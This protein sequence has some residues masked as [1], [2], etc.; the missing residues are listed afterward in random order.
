VSV[1]GNQDLLPFKFVLNQNYPNPFNPTTEIFF[2]IPKKQ[3]TEL[4]VYDI[5]GARVKTI[6]SRNLPA[7][8]YTVSWDGKDGMGQNVASGMYFYRLQSDTQIL[9]KKMVLIR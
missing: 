8:K 1:E 7:G 6:L 9:T 5:L 3:H 2:S 4:V